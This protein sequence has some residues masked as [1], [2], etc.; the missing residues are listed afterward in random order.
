MSNSDGVC[1]AARIKAVSHLGGEALAAEPV[2]DS[3]SPGVFLFLMTFF[4]PGGSPGL[5]SYRGNSSLFMAVTTC[6][7]TWLPACGVFVF[8]LTQCVFHT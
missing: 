3:T 1:G 7:D 2:A 8:E 4:R 5:S 6:P